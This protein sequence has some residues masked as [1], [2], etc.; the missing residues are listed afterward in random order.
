MA[1]RKGIAPT[2]TN[3][4]K[5]KD[6][7]KFAKLGY[8]LLDQKRTILINELLSLVDQAV[9]LEE[10]ADKSLDQAYMS[11]KQASL[12]VGKL[13]TL[14]LSSAVNIQSEIQLNQRKVMGV[15]LPVVNT[16]FKDFS[17]YFSPMGSGYWI[18][19]S[20][21]DFKE[22]L[23]LMGELAEMKIS[24]MRLAG[25]VKK[26]IR[27]VNAL[28]KIAIPELDETVSLVQ[29]RLEEIERESFVLMKMVKKRMEGGL[30]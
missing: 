21:E 24:I 20:V 13:K 15:A 22:A 5:L 30:K 3:L 2:K 17:P 23:Q 12:Q 18:D 9:L 29:N 11:L 27:K 6:E 14:S 7:L 26:T 1:V 8:E 19:R 16:D 10:K 28:E 25:E 4:L